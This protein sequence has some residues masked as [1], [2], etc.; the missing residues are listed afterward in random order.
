MTDLLSDLKT[1][2]A[3]YDAPVVDPVPPPNPPATPIPPEP[4]M[5][6]DALIDGLATGATPCGTQLP[7]AGMK[8]V[9]VDS[10]PPG[11]VAT[12]TNLV[13]SGFSGDW[14]DPQGWDLGG[15][16]LIFNSRCG[17]VR[18]LYSSGAANNNLPLIHVKAG[19][20]FDGMEF[21]DFL[22]AARAMVFKQEG[23]G[24]ASLLRRCKVQGM[25]QDAIKFSGG[26]TIE[27]NLIGPCKFRGGA[28]HADTFTAM[29]AKGGAVIRYNNVDWVYAGQ[30]DQTGINNW[31]RVEAYTVGAIF[32]DIEVYGNKLVHQSAGSFAIHVTTKNS[33]VWNGSIK[34]N[35]NRLKKA[36]GNQKI[37]YAPSSRISQWATNI[38][39]NTGL[40]IPLSAT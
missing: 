33:P 38:D 11:I 16:G 5:T 20:G 31:L 9:G 37:L 8:R 19:G 12:A 24:T 17:Y 3:K 25:S 6:T 22:N 35:D 13:F 36:G 23:N 4:P 30:T 27:E 29:A 28:P 14:D 1:L 2:V 15:R 34:V 39:M 40:E 32:D 26:I 7:I 21:C 18:N 10:L